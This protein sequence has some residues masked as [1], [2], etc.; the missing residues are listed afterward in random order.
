MTHTE[1]IT[2]YR[3]GRVTVE[4][5]R[6]RAGQ[7]LSARL[8]LP[9]LMLPLLGAG[10]ALALLG[11]IWSGL[12]LIAAGIIAPRL[13]KR[14]APH[15]LLTQMLGDEKLYADVQRAGIL[16]IDTTDAQPAKVDKP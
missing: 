4:F 3:G 5:Y 14:A 12:A 6:V 16:R 7:F 1:F 10:V 9:V 11:W 8:M 2:A 15:F 13:I